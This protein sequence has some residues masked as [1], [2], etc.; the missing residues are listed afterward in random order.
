MIWVATVI[1]LSAE[2]SFNIYIHRLIFATTL[3]SYFTNKGIVKQSDL[4]ISLRASN[5]RNWS[6]H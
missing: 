1:L 5:S 3:Y 6:S 2:P 4:A